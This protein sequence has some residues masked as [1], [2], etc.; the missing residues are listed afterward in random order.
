MDFKT[1]GN[2]A[3][4][5]KDFAKAAEYYT[6]G[7][8]QDA[9]NHILYSNRASA[10]LALSQFD[11][12][13]ADSTKS[14]EINPKWSKGWFRKGQALYGMDRLEESMEALEKAIELEP[15]DQFKKVLAEVE[16]KLRSR[17]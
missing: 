13:L 17:T 10:R 16:Q 5:K 7:I 6:Q 2:E 4:Q 14:V 11:D 9:N 15:S 1:L 8:A 3:L 12:A